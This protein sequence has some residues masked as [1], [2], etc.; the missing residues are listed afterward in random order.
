MTKGRHR[1][2]LLTNALRLAGE[3]GSDKL[4]VFV[5]TEREARRYLKAGL[6]GEEHVVLVLPRGLPVTRSEIKRAGLGSLESWSGNQTRFS[7]IKYAFLQGVLEG[8]ILPTSKVVCLIGPWGSDHLDT[9]TV[10]DLSLSWSQEF[11]FDVSSLLAKRSFPT[12]MA[13][14]DV[15]LDIGASGREGKPVGTMFVIGDEENVLRNSHQAVFN[16]FKGYA[17]SDRKIGRPEVVESI[18]ELALLDGAF[19]I[20][21]G[22][23]LEAAGRHLDA[24]G[25][26][27]KELR[28]LGSRH[29]AAAG[30]TRRTASV[31][32]VVSEST[33]RVTV[34]DRGRIVTT[35]EPYISRRLV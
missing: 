21:S 23:V 13:M 9:I 7:R 16:P 20:S 35:L 34:F 12:A 1:N 31:A 8:I 32:V 33:G 11:P 15:A 27:T 14:V 18:K 4:F 2:L 17:R 30:I 22:G 19:V 5:N 3:T 29:R 25:V 10:H 26:M 24:A 28:G 6:P